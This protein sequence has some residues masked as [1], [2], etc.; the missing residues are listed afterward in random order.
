MSRKSR[1]LGLSLVGVGGFAVSQASAQF[2]AGNVWPNSD[3]STPAAPGVDQVFNFFNTPPGSPNL[4]GDS[5]PRPDGWHRGNNDFGV[6]TAPQFCFYNTPGNSAGEGT[7]PAGSTNGFALE[8]NDTSL[9][10][11]G[12]WFSDFNALPAGTVAGTPIN[13]RFFWQYQNLQSTQKP[14]SS[15]Q[16]RVT[17]D[18]G[19][20]V[21]N[22]T[23][24]APNIID[25]VDDIIPTGS[26]DLDS[27]TEV[28]E[29]IIAPAGA[30]S[31]RLTIDSGGSS[32]ATGQIWVEDI[33]VAAVPEPA[34]IAGITAGAMILL[35]KRRRRA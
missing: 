26:P 14:E 21:G 28:D 20:A 2:L 7:A 8:I 5:N 33:S 3:L 30:E 13:V 31:L 27:W 11:S 29:Q 24:N 25:H 23:V 17:A 9:G 32:L 4:T 15:D 35:G 6:T 18:W 1:I 10:G 34:S 19:D 12:E 16:F 22:D